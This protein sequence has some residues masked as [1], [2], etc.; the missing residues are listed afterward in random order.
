M[1]RENHCRTVSEG[2]CDRGR[3]QTNEKRMDY[4]LGTVASGDFVRATGKLKFNSSPV[5]TVIVCILSY[6]LL[7]LGCIDCKRE[8]PVHLMVPSRRK[9]P[10]RI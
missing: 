8:A 10:A 3:Q 7:L 6:N 4:S 5:L 1:C 9:V 2:D